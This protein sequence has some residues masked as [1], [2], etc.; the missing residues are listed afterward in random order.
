MLAGIVGSGAE[1]AHVSDPA[2]SFS[3]SLPG[4]PLDF[5]R[6]V[7]FEQVFNL[8]PQPFGIHGLSARGRHVHDR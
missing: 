6:P 5:G 3:P 1:A 8:R 2:T 4:D 7:G